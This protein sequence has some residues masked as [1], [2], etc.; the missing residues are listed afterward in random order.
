[1]QESAFLLVATM[2]GE[3]L[4]QESSF[5]LQKSVI[6]LLAMMGAA[7]VQKL[8]FF[9]AH[10]D[11]SGVCARVGIQLDVAALKDTVVT[12]RNALINRMWE[13]RPSQMAKIVT[14]AEEEV[15]RWENGCLDFVRGFFGFIEHGS[16]PLLQECLH[17]STSFPSFV[18]E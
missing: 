13:R 2:M 16:M 1:M 8:G 7:S 12:L 15:S 5:L 10:K 6:L 3:A 11:G 4:V 17:K 14:N 9:V 18:G